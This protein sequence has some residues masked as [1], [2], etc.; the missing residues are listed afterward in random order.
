L[1]TQNLRTFILLANLKNFTH[2]ANQLFIAQSTVTNRIAELE[3]ELGK[4]LFFRNKKNISLTEEGQ[5]FLNYAKRIV[6]LEESSIHEMNSA[7]YYHDTLRIGTP[8]TVY[9]C[10]LYPIISSFL[11][12]NPEVAVKI[13]TGHSL[14]LL[15]M[16]QDGLLDIVFSY[17]PYQKTEYVC[18]PYV[19][20]ELVLVTGPQN[21]I[22]SE[23]IRKGELVQ[24]N[25]LFCNF[26]LQEVGL[27]IREL[28]PPFYQF[29]FEID[30]STKLIQYLLDGTGYSFLPKSLVKP[31]LE[32][33]ALLS[34][35]LLDFETPKINSYRIYKTTNVVV[36]KILE[37]TSIH[38]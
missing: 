13:I 35:S 25:Y 17:I 12:T 4:Q 20:D 21:K 15:Q 24:L 10:H 34:I 27:F 31:Y 33:G 2:T 36:N 22:Y 3:K 7:S 23:G 18:T 5:I 6:D 11:K 30:N 38:N 32:T 26:A 1:D 14:T 28:F 8:H 37:K 19:T 29:A 9:E 16:L